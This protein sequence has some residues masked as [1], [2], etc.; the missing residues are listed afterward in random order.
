MT[1]SGSP[2][3]V[4]CS[5]KIKSIFQVDYKE[6]WYGEKHIFSSGSFMIWQTLYVVAGFFEIFIFYSWRFMLV[7]GGFSCESFSYRLELF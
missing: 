2:Q 4:S 7:F 3:N 5:N 6:G 1:F